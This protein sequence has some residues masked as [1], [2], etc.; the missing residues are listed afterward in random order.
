MS[1]KM[2]MAPMT[3]PSASRKAEALRLVGIISPDALRGLRR[4]L[5]VAPRSMTSRK[6]AVNSRVSSGLIKRDSDCSSTSSVRK[7]SSSYTASFAE[8]ILPSRSETKTGSGAFLII[9]S[10]SSEPCDLGF[11]E[12]AGAD[13]VGVDKVLSD[14]KNLHI[15]NKVMFIHLP[16]RI[17]LFLCGART[18]D[19]SREEFIG[20]LVSKHKSFLDGL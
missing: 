18:W 12:C 15:H 6:A 16:K 10:A 1:R 14:M 8:R 13:I 2:P 4:A 11:W 7:P 19:N 20:S 9:I 17:R 3:L 5:R